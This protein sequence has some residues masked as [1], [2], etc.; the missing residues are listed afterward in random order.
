MSRWSLSPKEVLT[1]PRLG[2]IPRGQPSIPQ[3]RP[4]LTGPTLNPQTRPHLTGPTLNP[5]T[6][7]HLERP[8]L[9]PPDQAAPEANPR[10]A[11]SA[12]PPLLAA[13]INS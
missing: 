8:T 12:D 9:I 3:T 13:N 6:R 2:H 10:K 1:C 4:Q 7:P 5:Q 11:G